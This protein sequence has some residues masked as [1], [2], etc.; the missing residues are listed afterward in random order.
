MCDENGNSDRGI[1]ISSQDGIGAAY[2]ERYKQAI[3][4]YE[5]GGSQ[6]NEGDT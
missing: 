6:E 2:N 5:V 1:H 4:G 3:G